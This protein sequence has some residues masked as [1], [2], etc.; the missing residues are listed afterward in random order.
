MGSQAAIDS[1]PTVTLESGAGV[2]ARSGP[3]D[4]VGGELRQ[5]LRQITRHSAV[6][7]AGTVF[8]MA[9]SYGV[10]IYVVRILG[11][12]LLGIYALGMTLVSFMQLLGSLGMPGAAARYV[13]V[14]RA[15]GQEGQ[16]HG[17]LAKSS[18]LLLAL[19]LVLGGVMVWRGNWI[20]QHPYHSPMLG[21]YIPG[22]ALLMLLGAFSGFCAQVLAGFKDVAK[23]TVITNFVGTPAVLILTVAFL[24]AGARLWGYLAAQIFAT[25]II[26]ALLVRAIWKFLHSGGLVRSGIRV[27]IE[28]EV[29]SFSAATFA[30]G[31]IDFLCTQA[32]KILIGFYLAAKPVGIYVLASTLAAFVPLVLQSVNQIFAPVIADLHAQGRQQ[33][34][35]GLFQTL[36]KWVLILTLPLAMVVIV[37]AP[38][39]MGIFGRDFESGWPVLVIVA[40]G[41]I[42]NCAVGSVGSLLLMSGHQKKLMKVQ[43]TMATVSVLVNLTLIPLLGIIGAALA[44]A[45]V[46]IGGNVWNLVEVRAALKLCPYNRSYY[47]LLLPTGLTTISLASLRSMSLDVQPWL[48]VSLAAIVGCGTFIV[49]MWAFG[50]DEDDRL[51]AAD[52]IRQL[53]ASFSSLRVTF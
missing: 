40:V 50:V 32:D 45:L 29:L 31:G 5:T 35:Q 18:A 28:R 41:Q 46:N 4:L 7:F 52:S 13:A 42:V 53:R 16:L 22:F 30:M 26:V 1:N 10:K 39:L 23:R 44:A 33:L 6:F 3:E 38:Q 37:F 12:E 47:R 51:I 17:L 49:S 8:T 9:A 15:T 43:F 21:V 36:T 11:A 34:L 2:A 24:T 48:L 14:Y 27:P 19:N 25:T 20:A